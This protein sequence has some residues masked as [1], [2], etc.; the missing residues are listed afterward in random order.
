MARLRALSAGVFLLAA[1]LTQVGAQSWEDCHMFGVY[2][3][4]ACAANPSPYSDCQ[5]C[6]FNVCNEEF[7]G[8]GNSCATTC[9]GGGY[10]AC[11]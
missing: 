8:E 3:G 6:V 1:L 5:V 9:R 4:M 7:G 2:T 11:M 10:A